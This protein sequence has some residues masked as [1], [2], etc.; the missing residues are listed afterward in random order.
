MGNR[1]VLTLEGLARS[2]CWYP[3]QRSPFTARGFADAV[4]RS[5]DIQIVAKQC[6]NGE[7][8]TGWCI[9]QGIDYT[10]YYYMESSIMQRDRILFH[11]LGYIAMGHRTDGDRSRPEA[12]AI[13]LFGP[14]HQ[15]VSR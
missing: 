15:G 7:Y 1:P 3:N 10:I 8:T 6:Q 4:E 14:R 12:G 2:V 11:E 9:A 5:W 13:W